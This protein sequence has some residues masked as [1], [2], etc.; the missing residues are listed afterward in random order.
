MTAADRHA[1]SLFVAE[2]MSLTSPLM[3]QDYHGAN[4]VWLGNVGFDEEAM[5]GARSAVFKF[6][7]MKGVPVE[8]S[9][10]KGTA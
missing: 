9:P 5:S 10:A 6:C 4:L 2:F 8:M 1:V 7:L 3:A